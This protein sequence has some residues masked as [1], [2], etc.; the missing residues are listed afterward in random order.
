[1]EDLPLEDY[2][3]AF[4]GKLGSEGGCTAMGK[5]N[6]ENIYNSELPITILI[7]HYLRKKK[8]N[9]NGLSL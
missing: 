9:G 8:K 6:L 4:V 2:R 1:M 5:D 3:Q 7:D